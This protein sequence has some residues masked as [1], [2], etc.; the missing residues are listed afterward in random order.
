MKQK[1]RFSI[2]GA[3]AV[4]VMMFFAP[5]FI[6]AQAQSSSCTNGT[7]SGVDCPNEGLRAIQAAFPGSQRATDFPTLVRIII[8]WALYLSAIIAVIFIIIGGYFYITSAGNESQATKGRTTL[9]NALIGLAIIVL[10]Y[11]IVQVVYNFLTR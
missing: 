7:G 11:M 3:L 2:L 8:N 6:P 9:T 5:S 1:F 10:S 4:T